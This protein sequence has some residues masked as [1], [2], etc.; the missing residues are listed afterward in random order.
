LV[1]RLLTK[2][3]ISSCTAVVQPAGDIIFCACVRPECQGRGGVSWAFIAE[4]GG[5]EAIRLLSGIT[6]QALPV[7]EDHPGI[8]G[9]N[10]LMGFDQLVP[11]SP[12]YVDA[13]CELMEGVTKRHHRYGR[14]KI[15]GFGSF[16]QDPPHCL[17][18]G[19][20]T[21]DVLL[22][23]NPKLMGFAEKYCDDHMVLTAC[24]QCKA[25]TLTEEGS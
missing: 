10:Q 2:Q 11:G 17:D 6:I 16:A 12:E 24:P 25:L 13:H 20:G 4:P 9:A 19:H 1:N 18:C 5:M 8:F 7:I 23:I 22:T 21:V 15:G 14:S 3:E